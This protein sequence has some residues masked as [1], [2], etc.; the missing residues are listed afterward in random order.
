MKTST[1]NHITF[2]GNTQNK[3]SV[4]SFVSFI[5]LNMKGVLVFISNN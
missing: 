5:Y 1:L 3:L 4:F 2:V